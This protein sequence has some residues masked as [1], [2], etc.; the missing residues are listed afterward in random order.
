MISSY[1]IKNTVLETPR[2]VLRKM[3]QSDTDDMYDYAR[4]EETSK[5]LLWSPHTNKIT[6]SDTLRVILKEYSAGKFYDFAVVWKETGRMIGTAGFTTVDE[7]NFCA[8]IGYVINPDYWNMG[9]A[10]EAVNTLLNFA[11]CELGMHRVEAKYMV[12]NENSRKVMEKCG[13]HFE[14]VSKGKLLVKGIYRDIGTCAILSEEYFL[15]ERKNI[16]QC[17]RQIGFFH[18]LFHKN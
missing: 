16:Y 15:T 13:M 11:F 3:T 18:R 1:F 17:Q 4:R 12:Q 8:E 7:K 14:G 9:I 2:L 10:T 5:Y 6:T